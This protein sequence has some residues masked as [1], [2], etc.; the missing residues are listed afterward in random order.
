VNEAQVS[1][2]PSRTRLTQAHGRRLFSESEEGGGSPASQR[3]F[4]KGRVRPGGVL[5]LHLGFPDIPNEVSG[6]PG[7]NVIDRVDAQKKYGLF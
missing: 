4:F 2:S 6:N 1:G 7:C 5:P 3:R